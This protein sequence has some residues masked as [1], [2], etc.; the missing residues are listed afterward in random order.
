MDINKNLEPIIPKMQYGGDNYN[1]NSLKAYKYE[2]EMKREVD[3]SKTLIKY[4]LN[5][6]FSLPY[7]TQIKVS[8]PG[9]PNPITESFSLIELINDKLTSINASVCIST[10]EVY[11]EKG[12]VEAICYLH[13]YSPLTIV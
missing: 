8:D 10:Y 2:K 7:F 1:T 11:K 9:D 5:N 12:I 4:H 13:E 6:R 3:R